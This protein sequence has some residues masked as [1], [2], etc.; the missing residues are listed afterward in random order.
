MPRI[1]SPPRE[2]L[3]TLWPRLT[4]GELEV[5]NFLD[6]RIPHEWEIYIQPHLNGLRPDFVLLHPECGIVVVEVKDWNLSG[7]LY[8]VVMTEES[9]KSAVICVN[10]PKGVKRIEAENPFNKIDLYR[11]EILSLYCPSFAWSTQPGREQR[12]VYGLLIFTKATLPR[13]ETVFGPMLDK[14]KL[15]EATRRNNCRICGQDTLSRNNAMLLIEQVQGKKRDPMSAKV[16]EDLRSWLV[17]PDFAV[18]RRL[19]LELDQ[20]KMELVLTRSQRLHRKIRGPAGCGKSLVLAARAAQLCLEGKNVMVVTYNITLIQYI[21]SLAFRWP[22]PGQSKVHQHLT[23][24]NFH[25]WCRRIAA[26]YGKDEE[27]SA[28]FADAQASFHNADVETTKVL[29][30]ELPAFIEDIFNRADEDVAEYDAILV[31]EGQD[32]RPEWWNCLRR[33]LRTGGEMLL[34]ADAT[35]DIYGRSE[36]WTDQNMKGCMLSPTWVRLEGS[37]RAPAAFRPRLRDFAESFLAASDRDPPGDQLDFLSAIEGDCDLSWIQVWKGSIVEHLVEMAIELMR[38]RVPQTVAAADICV[39]A[40][41]RNEGLAVTRMLR[42]R[43][44]KVEDTF[45][46]GGTNMAHTNKIE[47]MKKLAFY[48]NAGSIK[49]TT[50]HSFKGLESRALVIG[51]SKC[52]PGLVYTAISRLKRSEKGSHLRV[53]CD[54]M[55]YLEFGRRWPDFREI[56]SPADHGYF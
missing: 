28:L 30:L 45:F 5:L 11:N 35:Q 55:R 53:V 29:E 56:G 50:I 1:I 17:E 4:E 46:A 25:R 9:P 34:V 21:R 18:E 44:F 16:A 48:P 41:N 26:K 7:D 2:K 15:R 3:D 31:D 14:F 24:L 39:V 38:V 6:K 32:F 33:V 49:V 27:Y 47:R 20:R 22:Q 42:E 51:V 23:L 54:D 10:T 19:P 37:Y 8:S 43:H 36:L 52:D 12:V 13:A 40:S